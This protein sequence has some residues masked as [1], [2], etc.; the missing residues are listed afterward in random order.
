MVQIER[1]KEARTSFQHRYPGISVGISNNPQG[2]G[3]VLAARVIST[4]Q[5]E[6]MPKEID[7]VPIVYRTLVSKTQNA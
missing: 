1:V 2:T 5:A 7:G 6:N 4:E 3:Y